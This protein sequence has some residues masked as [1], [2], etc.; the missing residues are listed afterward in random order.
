MLTMLLLGMFALDPVVE[1][2]LDNQGMYWPLIGYNRA[3]IAADGTFLILSQYYLWH[4][5][6]NG[7]LIRR[8]GGKG[9]GPGEFGL[10]IDAL[11]DGQY[12]WVLDANYR[13]STLYNGQGRFLSKSPIY[14]R[15]LVRAH[16]HLFGLDISGF[17][18]WR[19]NYPPVLQEIGFRVEDQELLVEPKEDRFRKVTPRQLEFKFNFKLLWMVQKNGT[20]MVMDQLEPKIFLYDHEAIY[21][22]RLTQI[23]EPYTPPYLPVQLRRWVE[24]PTGFQRNIGT[25]DIYRK[26]WC[27]WS[28]VTFFCEWDDHFFVAYEIPD[29]EDDEST[30]QVMQKIA[31]DGRAI[32]PAVEVKGFV[33]GVKNGTAFV[34]FEDEFSDEFTYYFRGYSW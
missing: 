7:S 12:Y 28:R 33:A 3:S 9:E 2:T 21:R 27:S 30:I 34:L 18:P 4:L 5:N 26:W 29:P 14:F 15:Q 8:L 25:Q 1:I 6:G 22:E 23:D 20:Y 32:G 24:P 10:L 11:W 16:D 19:T 31:V 17:D 13:M